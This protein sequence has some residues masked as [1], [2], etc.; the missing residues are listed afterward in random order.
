M[1]N[2]KQY[3]LPVPITDVKEEDSLDKLTKRY[4]KLIEPSKLSKFGDKVIDVLPEQVKKLGTGV[5]HAISEQELYI[6]SMKIVADGFKIVEEHA[7]KFTISEKSILKKLN[8][9]VPH[10]NI[11]S[12]NEVCL[13]R[14]YDISKLVSS[15]KNKDI[16]LAFVEGGITGIFGFAGLPFNLVLSTF[17]YYRAVQSIAMYYGYDVKND[18]NELVISSEVFMS[19]LSPGRSDANGL[20]DIIGKVMLI[21]KAT[22]VKQAAKKSWGEMAS[23]NGLELLIAQMRALANISA[24]N[25]L[26]KA[27]KKGLEQSIFK[28]VFEQ[29]GR[30][31]TLKTVQRAVPVI[32]GLIS[33]CFDTAQ[34]NKVL[35][36][37][38]V[39]YNKR[40]ILEKQ[41]RI[42]C[43]VG[44]INDEI[45]IENM[46]ELNT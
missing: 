15:Y 4:E 14:G 12:L 40:Y 22:A 35:E 1:K 24:K 29:I 28:D 44:V 42:D 9:I 46:E 3:T 6:Q 19:A 31:L 7:A 43:I 21:S 18:A 39:F 32:S 5:G 41:Y 30:K 2:N 8:E 45:I 36:Y 38:D 10:N 17:L 23:R 27:G 34:M 13:A 26:E 33:A 16:G 11:T 37:A 25:A 20:T